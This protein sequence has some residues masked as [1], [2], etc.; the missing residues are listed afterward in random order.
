MYS[1]QLEQQKQDMN[2][3]WEAFEELKRLE[4]KYGDLVVFPE[5]ITILDV[6]DA[7]LG[8][9]KGPVPAKD[10]YTRDELLAALQVIK[11][12]PGANIPEAIFYAVLDYRETQKTPSKKEKE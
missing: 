7:E 2:R 3:V 9:P 12:S 5:V 4:K 1:S 10:I 6:A 11:D 8:S